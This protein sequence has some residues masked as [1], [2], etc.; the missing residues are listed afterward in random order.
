MRARAADR[1][2]RQ[3]GTTLDAGSDLKR[4]GCALDLFTRDRVDFL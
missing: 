1:E 2:R 4:A 3:G